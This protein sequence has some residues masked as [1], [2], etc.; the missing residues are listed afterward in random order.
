MA[1]S[2][3]EVEQRTLLLVD[4]EAMI[5]TLTRRMLEDLGVNFLT[6]ASGEEAIQISEQFSGDIDVAL[7]DMSMP[8]MDGWETMT[9]LKQKRPETRVIICS[10]SSGDLDEDSLQNAGVFSCLYKPFNLND[11]KQRVISAFS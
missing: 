1:A 11:L 5:I 4:D 10:G 6:A 2:P 9:H 3:T 7:I 8:G